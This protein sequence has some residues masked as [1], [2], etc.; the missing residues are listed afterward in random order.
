M[1]DVL[2]CK[3]P[4]LTAPH[5]KAHGTAEN[6]SMRAACRDARCLCRLSSELFLRPAL[7]SG[8]RNQ[9][10]VFLETM[11]LGHFRSKFEFRQAN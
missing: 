6:G 11:A 3:T 8:R 7:L 1:L 9:F 5:V 4:A 2:L 10:S